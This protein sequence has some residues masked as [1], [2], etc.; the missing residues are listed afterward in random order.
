MY[1]LRV[2]AAYA[3]FYIIKQ[4]RLVQILSMASI[5]SQQRPKVCTF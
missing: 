1:A 4:I 3:R 5:S 2:T